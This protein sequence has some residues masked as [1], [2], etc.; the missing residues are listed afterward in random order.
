MDYEWWARNFNEC[1]PKDGEV[2]PIRLPEHI[3]SMFHMQPSPEKCEWLNVFADRYFCDMKKSTLFIEKL[4]VI[5]SKQIAKINPKRPNF[6]GEFTVVSVSPGTDSVHFESVRMME[7]TT[8]P[9]ELVGEMKIIYKG[10]A[11]VTIASEVYINWP[12]SK[13]AKVPVMLSVTLDNLT[14]TLQV[15]GPKEDFSRFSASFVNIEEPKFNANI[16]LGEKLQ[17]SKYFRQIKQFIINQLKKILWKHTC[18][19][20]KI[21]FSLPLPGIKLALKTIKYTSRRSRARREHERFLLA[22]AGIPLNNP[23]SV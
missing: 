3:R 17:I 20:N 15:Y 1:I 19:P 21:T 23:G 12:T 22:Q 14:G 18:T 6:L 2:S 4:M 7:S 9:G 5:M 10:S 8:T 16:V 13:F 11:S